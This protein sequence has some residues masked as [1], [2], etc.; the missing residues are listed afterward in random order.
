IFPDALT[1]HRTA[2]LAD[3]LRHAC[4]LAGR[5]MRPRRLHV[6]LHPVG[7]YA[8]LPADVVGKAREA[9]SSLVASPFDITF[10]RVESFVQ[11]HG[12]RPLVLRSGTS[13]KPLTALRR[14]L[15][16]ALVCRGLR[17]AARSF[18]PHMT[19]LY[20]SQEI[21]ARAVEPVAW[22][23]REFVLVHSRWGR[24]QHI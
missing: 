20:D 22:T 19:L 14:A 8:G 10:D 11:T 5:P 2:D 6:S 3:G 15:G 21:D 4:G 24:T 1:A 12:H 17:R 16:D 7:E 18:T 9:A 13:L 23:V